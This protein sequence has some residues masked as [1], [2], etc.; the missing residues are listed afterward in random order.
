MD[1]SAFSG[2]QTRFVKPPGA[3]GTESSG[4]REKRTETE[5]QTI[6]KRSTEEKTTERS[7]RRSDAATDGK[8]SAPWRRRESSSP[9]TERIPEI[10]DDVPWRKR[11][12]SEDRKATAEV[13][14]KQGGAILRK[15][16]AAGKPTEE[17]A[18]APAWKS[19]VEM[20][21]KGKP[22]ANV[23]DTVPPLTG[24]AEV[25]WKS[26]AQM[27]KKTSR[28]NSPARKASLVEEIPSVPWKSGPQM[29][30]K[31]SRESSPTRKASLVVPEE[32]PD[33]PWKSGAQLL[34]KT[35]RES[36]PTRKSSLV[37]PPEPEAPWK[38]GQ[39]FLNKMPSRDASPAGRKPPD[40]AAE[41]PWKSGQQLLK[42]MP[43][44]DASPAGQNPP[45]EAAA[46]PWKS[47]KLRK[48]SGAASREPS[49]D[50]ESIPDG[51]KTS[52]KSFLSGK[53]A[54]VMQSDRPEPLPPVEIKPEESPQR[55]PE[56]D[57]VQAAPLRPKTTAKRPPI[58]PESQPPQV[59][60]KR[61]PQKARAEEAPPAPVE[62]KPIPLRPVEAKTAEPIKLKPIP[63]QAQGSQQPS[64]VL[65]KRTP[66]KAGPPPEEIQPSPHF[67]ELKKVPLKTTATA[68]P[69]SPQVAQVLPDQPKPQEPSIPE[70]PVQSEKTLAAAQP[71]ESAPSTT[72]QV[73]WRKPRPAA[74]AVQPE[75]SPAPE[76]QQETPS[77]RKPRPAVVQQPESTPS[78]AAPSES[79][80]QEPQPIA[81]AEPT[82]KQPDGQVTTTAQLPM[83]KQKSKAS[84]VMAPRSTPPVFTKKL[85][86]LTSRP[87][88]KIR[89]HCTFTGEPQPSVTWYRNESTL[90]ASDRL[91]I[92]SETDS[93]V[94][95]ISHLELSDTGIYT[96]RAVNEAGSAATSANFI[97]AGQFRS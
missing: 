23:V 34:K 58:E 70:P 97:V 21:R 46:V 43:S 7:S 3:K 92:T 69:E 84:L 68:A 88:K 72:D 95:E 77:W 83:R 52:A 38:S 60:L 61:S 18:A 63:G 16:A 22:P 78:P 36:S 32:I 26:G 10:Q 76:V 87:G 86:P 93:S 55:P 41:A 47:V 27:L 51:K 57:A 64:Q 75:A 45:D 80:R 91:A 33:V 39:Q 1:R 73:S 81:A 85:Q 28:E 53:L 25:P 50:K 14:W 71:A 11:S 30:K 65:L 2:K 37:L 67:V 5:T 40:E 94:L 19:G 48:A 6:L 62:L 8:Q 29:L 82:D 74:T 20:L 4:G 31:T 17:S 42:K 15:P 66:Q 89:F 9:P 90:V 96:C 79:V 44:R 24:G 49:P 54:K 35:S 12:Q 56:G 13:P 59:L